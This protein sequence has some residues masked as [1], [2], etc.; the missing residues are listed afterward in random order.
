MNYYC[1]GLCLVAEKVVEKKG[2]G[3]KEKLID[4]SFGFE[5]KLHYSV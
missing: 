2:K 5:C 3:G 4:F 1:L